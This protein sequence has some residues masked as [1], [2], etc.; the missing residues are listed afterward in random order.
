MS[1][2]NMSEIDFENIRLLADY[3]GEY[4]VN[5]MI[6]EISELNVELARIEGL[7]GEALR[8]QLF[9][10]LEEVADVTIMLNQFQ[11]YCE[12][13]INSDCCEWLDVAIEQKIARALAVLDIRGAEYG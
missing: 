13:H 2:G 9:N 8:R 3:N 11:L 10:V 7:S 5:K 4:V 6:E 12:R 1:I